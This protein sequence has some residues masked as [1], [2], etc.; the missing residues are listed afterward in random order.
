MELTTTAA[1]AINA[2]VRPAP[3]PASSPGRR[4]IRSITADNRVADAAVPR[5]ATAV[6]SPPNAASPA[7]SA[8]TSV[9]TVPAAM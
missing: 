4:P 8:A 1:T 7:I 5:T 6:G 9:P 3:R 2:P